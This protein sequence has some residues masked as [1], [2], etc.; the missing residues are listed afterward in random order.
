MF[1]ALLQLFLLSFWVVSAV[2][3]EGY[4]GLDQVEDYRVDN[5]LINSHYQNIIEDYSSNIHGTLDA[6]QIQQR[7][8]ITS[9]YNT[10]VQHFDSEEVFIDLGGGDCINADK[11]ATALKATVWCIEPLMHVNMS[12]LSNVHYVQ[13]DALA[14]TDLES[15][16]YNF[17]LMKEVLHNIPEEER[18]PIFQNIYHQLLPKGT[19]L[20]MTRAPKPAFLLTKLFQE[21]WAKTSLKLDEVLPQLNE[22]GFDVTT[23]S[24]DFTTS[25]AKE[26]WKTFIQDRTWSTF[27]TFTDEEIQREIREIDRKYPQGDHFN[28]T[29]NC[30]FIV[31]RK[32]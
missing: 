29:D 9:I 5:N 3:L 13:M 2:G 16:R 1:R 24:H 23:E 4:M 18:K 30:I 10:T 27:A 32:L 21:R 11:L 6:I 25:I 22:A 14:F 28:F 12:A 20:I 19:F 7:L 31:A 8:V 15:I 17:L 26:S